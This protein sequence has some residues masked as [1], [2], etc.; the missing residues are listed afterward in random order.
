MDQVRSSYTW[1][2]PAYRRF[3]IMMFGH[4]C[5]VQHHALSRPEGRGT[6][7]RAIG[8][9]QGQSALPCVHFTPRLPCRLATSERRKMKKQKVNA[10]ND[11]ETAGYSAVDYIKCAR[12]P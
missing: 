11:R 12:L 2:K 8:D 1:F 5:V 4:M 10:Y 7:H 9:A 6:R 3:G